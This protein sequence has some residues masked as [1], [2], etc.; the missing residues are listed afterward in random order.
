MYDTLKP[1][2]SE[3][4]AKGAPNLISGRETSDGLDPAL[5]G[6][7]TRS[8]LW[9]FWPHLPLPLLYHCRLATTILVYRTK[10]FFKHFMSFFNTQHQEHETRHLFL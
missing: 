6:A 10:L 8:A 5:V 4:L 2:V 7:P 1:S 3:N 9:G